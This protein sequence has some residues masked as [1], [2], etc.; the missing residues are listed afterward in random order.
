[1]Y[2]AG[3]KDV[4]DVL[5]LAEEGEVENDLQRFGVGGE[6]DEL[7]NT[8]IEQNMITKTRMLASS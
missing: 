4:R 3:D 7:G 2:L 5:V 8:P 1:L 6:N